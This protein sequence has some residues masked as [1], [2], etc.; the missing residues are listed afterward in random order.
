MD[1]TT[2]KSNISKKH[3]ILNRLRHFLIVTTDSDSEEND[4]M[5]TKYQIKEIKSAYNLKPLI[6]KPSPK[7]KKY[8]Q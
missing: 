7:E 2:A 8:I 1:L 5:I 6:W 4:E 3:R